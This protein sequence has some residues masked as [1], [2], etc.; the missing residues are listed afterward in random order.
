M[1]L[2]AIGALV[3]VAAPTVWQLAAGNPTA[4]PSFSIA[5]AVVAILTAAIAALPP[6]LYAARRDPL[7]ELRVP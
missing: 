5:V 6:A 7:H 1:L 2:A 4:S 3:G